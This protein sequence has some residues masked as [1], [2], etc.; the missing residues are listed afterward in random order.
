MKNTFFFIIIPFILLSCSGKVN[1]QSSLK[2]ISTIPLEIAEPSG[3]TA[4]KNHLYIVSDHTGNIYKTTLKGTIVEK[5]KTN[6]TDL[7]GISIEPISKKIVLVN[8]AKRSLIYLS[9]KG[10][11]LNKYKIKGNQKTANS[12]LEGVCFDPTKERLYAINEKEPKQLL[13]LSLKGK[14]KD[15]YPLKFG[16]DFSGICYDKNLDCLW[17]ISDESKTI[18]QVTKK[19][20]LLKSYKT[21]IEKGEGIVIYKKHLYVV[22]DSLNSLF[23][24]EIPS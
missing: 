23:V 20:N 9:L 8:E 5:F 18:Y 16:R 11:F 7:E 17:L 10:K 14:I 6:Y 12:G 21:S 19:G 1:S 24:F 3:V 15:T 13:K 4:Y 22:S 2:L